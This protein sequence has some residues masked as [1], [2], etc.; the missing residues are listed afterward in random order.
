[1]KHVVSVLLAASFGAFSMIAVAQKNNSVAT[2]EYGDT[3]S[4]LVMQEQSVISGLVIETKRGPAITGNRG[5]LLLKG[6]NMAAMVGENVRVTGVIRG[7]V[8]YP[9]KIASK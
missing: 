4:Q 1:M 6:D 2:E 8:L 5:T 7:G 3:I 9:V